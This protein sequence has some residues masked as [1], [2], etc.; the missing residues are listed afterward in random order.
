MKIVIV[1]T[2][3]PLRGGIAHYV[4]LLAHH[5]RRRHTVEVL[6]FKR[7]YPKL[8]F[9]GKSQEESGGAILPNQEPAPQVLDSINPCNWIRVARAIRRRRP[10]LL[11]FK[12]WLP[13]F[14]PCFG[15]IARLVKRSAATKVLFIC[16]NVIPHERRLG[17]I[18]FTK[19]A[20]HSA[21]F[22]IAQSD[23]VEEALVEHFPDSIYRKTPHPVYEIFGSPIEKSIARRRLNISSKNVILFFGY[24]R[25]YK[26]VMVL[27]DAMRHL[28]AHRAQ[29]GD[30]LLLVIGEFYDDEKKYHQQVRD[31]K[32]ESCVRFV[33]D[34]VPNDEVALYFS[35]AD[36]VALP[37]LSA[38][39]SGIAQI[40]YHFDKPLIATDVGG[41]AEVVRHEKTGFVVPPRDPVALAAALRR[42]YVENRESEFSANVEIEKRNYSWGRLV[43]SIEELVGARSWK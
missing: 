38:T 17:D 13:F 21:D 12:Y 41:L 5:L 33:A 40:A 23:T 8:L 37:Y 30:T 15:T 9:P 39:Q 31:L 26:G 11:I 35:A 19:F 4:G 32:L 36:V 6:T 20:F 24:V 25:P 27:L 42:F 29:I 43:E 10:D 28:V 2:A 16:D 1:S 18:V 3:F 34:Y 14:G 22:F 7:Q